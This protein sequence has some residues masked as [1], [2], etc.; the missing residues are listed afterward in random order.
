MV[1]FTRSIVV[2]LALAVCGILGARDPALGA[3]LG[4]TYPEPA[5]NKWQFSVTPYGWATSINGDIT[6]RG[7]TV[8]VN[9]GFIDIVEKSNSLLAWMTYFEAGQRAVSLLHRLRLGRHRVPR[10]L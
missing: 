4:P 2:G 7:R 3:D 6:A 8:D 9:E 10:S 5:T 1:L